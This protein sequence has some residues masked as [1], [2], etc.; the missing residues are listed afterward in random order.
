M[1]E[2]E[3]KAARVAS[4][5]YW[6]ARKASYIFHTK[7]YQDAFGD[8]YKETIRTLELALREVWA[9][10]FNAFDEDE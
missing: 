9:G 4:R 1:N 2:E 3:K 10:G 7:K 6:A 5:V 8:E